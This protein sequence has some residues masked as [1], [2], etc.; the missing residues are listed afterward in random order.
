VTYK[1]FLQ[2]TTTKTKHSR[3]ADSADF[4]PSWKLCLQSQILVT[5]MTII[6]VWPTKWTQR[7]PQNIALT[8]LEPQVTCTENR[9]LWTCEV[10]LRGFE[11][12]EQAHRQTDRQTDKHT[13]ITILHI[14]PR[15][16]VINNKQKIILLFCYVA[17]LIFANSLT[18]RKHMETK[19]N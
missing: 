16:K 1:N 13:L 4:T 17:F 19:K 11:T 2:K 10:S 3:I 5:M 6:C 15:D 8:Q 18:Y 9:L 7:H 12:C 14:S